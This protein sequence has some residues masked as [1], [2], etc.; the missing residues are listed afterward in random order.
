MLVDMSGTTPLETSSSPNE[1]WQELVAWDD[2][3]YFQGDTSLIG[4]QGE[5]FVTDYYTTESI[6]S[7][8]PYLESTPASIAGGPPS[9]DNISATPS[10]LDGS[11]SLGQGYS[12]SPFLDTTATSPFLSRDEA[13]YF[14]SFNVCDDSFSSVG[15]ITESPVLDTRFER[16]EDSFLVSP[17]SYGSQCDTV[18]NPYVAGS[19]HSFSGLDIKASQV[20]SNV[21]TWADQP[22]II[23]P[24]TEGDEMQVES[25]DVF[26]PPSVSRSLDSTCPSQMP[27]E[28]HH[29]R[30]NRSRAIT[31]PEATWRS[32]NRNLSISKS[33]WTQRAPSAFSVSP[34]SHRR[35]SGAAL[36]RSASQSRHKIA[37]LSPTTDSYGWVSYH[38]NPATQRLAPTSTEGLQGRTPRGRKKGLTPEQR[39]H[40][41]LMRIV[42]ACSN[43]K[44]RK[45]KCDPGT[46]CKS[47]LE[48][49]KG[50]LV[51]HPCRDRLLSDLSSVFLSD[52]FGWHPTVRSL[53]AFVDPSSFNISTG[54]TYTIPLDFGFGPSLALPVY[55]VQVENLHPLIH[56]HIIYSWPPE[57]NSLSPHTHAV[58]PAVLTP[59]ATSN[60]VQTLDSHLSLLVTHHFRAF[61]LY[62]SPLRILREVYILSR[63]LNANS[64]PARILHQ[65][66]KLL[67][68][69]HIGGD[70]TLPS[71]SDNPVL[72]QLIRSTMNTGDKLNP[73]PCFIRSQFGA[74]MPG[75]ALNLLKD[76]LSSLE[77]LLL[78]RDCDE[79]PVVLA[80]IITI[81]MTVESIHYHAA[82]LPYHHNYST[83]P[84]TS[85]DEDRRVDDE[86]VKALLAFYT[87][88]FPGCHSR[89]RPDWEGDVTRSQQPGSSCSA[90]EAFIM[91]V[92]GA[93]RNANTTGYLAGKASE[94][95]Q[96][97][98]MSFFFDRLVARL[99][100]LNA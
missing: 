46:P 58:L 94:K 22:Q 62:C 83:A 74:V 34:V 55:A 48:H 77:Q 43:C 39:T 31:I 73:T 53:D 3:F 76:V 85:L 23:G 41:A 28:D 15:H 45:E 10:I 95:R 17:Q 56:E 21:G 59:D 12:T 44:L 32:Q 60:L 98:D 84:R 61:P 92:R 91:G 35:P 38:P 68:L 67:V 30:Q 54:I 93:V 81:L 88:C 24:I 33:R 8:Q 89:L 47:C 37:S 26:I 72:A 16:I 6:S 80:I 36:S 70:I 65:A 25:D 1:G 51:K 71:Q 69:V 20:F 14:G 5:S 13:N 4:R 42:G 100:F 50:D 18:F 19:S 29:Q 7:E 57:P 11:F 64:P 86:G 49:Y 75:L 2:E 96:G 87:A 52:R 99:L 79:W 40:A 9:F 63:S 78:K 97:D 66:L 90:E 27:S 82:K